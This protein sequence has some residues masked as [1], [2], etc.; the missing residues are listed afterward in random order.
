MLSAKR[1][2]TIT[3]RLLILTVG[4]AMPI[5]AFSVFVAIHDAEAQRADIEVNAQRSLHALAL[6]VE[7]E[8]S[9]V[10]RAARLLA[11]SS[12]QLRDGDLEGFH[13]QAREALKV[14]GVAIT[15]SDISGQ[16]LINTS[17]DYGE[18]LP[19]L[20]D[21]GRVK[22][23]FEADAPRVSGVTT[24]A[25]QQRPMI[26]ID[27]PVRD[28]A[29]GTP[30][31]L[32]VALAPA[33]FQ[34]ILEDQHL[35]AEWL[36]AIAD[37]SGHFIAR[38]IDAERLVGQKLTSGFLGQMSGREGSFTNTTRES[39]VVNSS[40]ERLPGSDW[41]AVIAVPR[42]VLVAPLQNSLLLGGLGAACALL[43]ATA[44]A[45]WGG[46]LVARPFRGLARSALAIAGDERPKLPPSG[47][48]EATEVGAALAATYDVLRRQEAEKR[49]S[50]QRLQ[51]SE[52]LRRE[53]LDAAEIGTWS[54]R[55]PDGERVW[56]ENFRRLFGIAADAPAT[57]DVLHKVV[58]P[59]DLDLV[60][61]TT[62]GLLQA[63]TPVSVDFR[64]IAA[65]GEVHWLRSRG[66]IDRH[67]ADG[68]PLGAKGVIMNIDALKQSERELRESE[69]R[70][71]AIVESAIDAIIVIDERGCIQAF[72]RSA[73]TMLGYAA[74]E[75]V[76][77]K[78]SMLMP[79][80]D[81]ARHDSYIER[82]LRTS[83]PHIIGTGREVE[84]RRKDG[85][86][87]PVALAVAEWWAGG[88]RYFTG[89]LRDLTKQK[90]EARAL[91]KL[92][93]QLRQSQKMEAIGQL[94]GGIAHDFNN[95][96]L[97]I[98]LNVEAL[99]EECA[100]L[101]A[102][103]QLVDSAMSATGHARTLIGHLLAFGRRQ[104][105]D[106]TAF[107]VNEAV[108]G[109]IGM[110]RRTVEASIAIE[111]ELREGVSQV[112]A[113][114]Q[115][116]ETAVLNLALN[117]RDAMPRGGR[118]VIETG[119]FVV[120]DDSA[121]LSPEMAPGNYVSIAVADT[122]TGMSPEVLARAFEPFY[123]TKASGE[124][125]GLGLSQVYGY[126]KQSGGHATI[127]SE[128]G[129][130]TVVR[131]YLPS[132]AQPP[133]S[134]EKSAALQMTPGSGETILMVEDTAIVRSAVK[135]MLTALGYRVIDVA[136]GRE[137]LAEL[138]SDTAIDLLF[139]D[140]ILPG[141]MGGSEL[142]LEAQRLRPGIRVLLTSGYTKTKMFP[143]AG[144]K[145][146]LPLL[147]KPY[148]KSELAERLVQ[149]LR[150]GRD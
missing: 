72:N 53:A 122:G 45:L 32:S 111:T 114:R 78:V 149:V 109:M 31:L 99:A 93:G 107:D 60:V 89:I 38:S 26:A 22:A 74:A 145:T 96:L 21:P 17:R 127:D 84:A 129:H 16:Q 52:A 33:V 69:D 24:A 57:L 88:A 8:L 92:E 131:L 25:I 142:V 18:A 113:D 23:A 133:A 94:T 62:E 91:A 147:S 126:V 136:T 70:H 65:N 64:V 67:D 43:L 36:G 35:P 150:L 46:R 112:V 42:Q 6:A 75:V 66:G 29:G 123:T 7:R 37:A 34:K 82:Y 140:M 137:A 5:V 146:N 20:V 76:G 121:A 49:A 28:T 80:D 11:A 138:E 120:D 12:S 55:L 39:V 110:L 100:E 95:L 4:V 134:V 15:L 141:G 101:P 58:H 132:S 56:D 44:A 9:G 148:T 87:F 85:S 86:L 1:D 10:E 81:A 77:R 90:A 106:A 40:F 98:S 83:E 73:E 47:V 119:N 116:L 51:E 63:E 13:R 2:L 103:R 130:G 48:R 19:K 128:L 144:P 3:V 27:L 124:G 59:A 115:Q 117:A 105:L 41:L 139:T 68:N 102:A 14:A 50:D 104:T 143:T 61:T 71:R 118:L 135:R 108:R 97:A 125:T 30:Y 54:I 79:R